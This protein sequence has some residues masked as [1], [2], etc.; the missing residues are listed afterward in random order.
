MTLETVDLYF[1][2]GFY[3]TLGK[4]AKIFSFLILCMWH[5]SVFRKTVM[6]TRDVV[7]VEQCTFCFEKS[8]FNAVELRLELSFPELFSCPLAEVRIE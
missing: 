7:P 4:S 3:Y 6:P 8:S 5:D 2:N 1:F